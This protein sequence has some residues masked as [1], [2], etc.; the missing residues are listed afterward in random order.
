MPCSCPFNRTGTKIKWVG[1]WA[2]V[3]WAWS[4]AFKAQFQNTGCVH[5]SVD[6]ALWYFDRINIESKH[7]F[8]LFQWDSFVQCSSIHE[9]P[10]GLL[11]H[12]V[13]WMTLNEG[14]KV[15]RRVKEKEVSW[16]VLATGKHMS[17]VY[18]SWKNLTLFEVM[19]WANMNV[20]SLLHTLH[21]VDLFS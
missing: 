15:N 19:I 16:K 6:W 13:I 4:M 21:L 3:G 11:S 9:Q 20:W 5:F 7:K 10:K 8:C 17:N 14:M 12:W 18:R 1:W 2:Q